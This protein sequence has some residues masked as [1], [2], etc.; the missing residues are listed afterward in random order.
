V[1]RIEYG[2]PNK[3]INQ[4]QLI[5]MNRTRPLVFLSRSLAVASPKP[6][7]LRSLPSRL[8]QASKSRS[9]VAGAQRTTAAVRDVHNISGGQRPLASWQYRCFASSSSSKDGDG[10]VRKSSPFAIKPGQT[11]KKR[12]SFVPPKAAVKLTDKARQFFKLLLESPP[13]PDVIGT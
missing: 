11:K 13:R 12:R 8:L 7:Q 1:E 5:I 3:D 9:S 6:S 4:Q 2:V 10:G